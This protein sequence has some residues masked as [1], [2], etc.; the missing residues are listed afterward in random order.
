MNFADARATLRKMAKGRR[1]HTFEHH[2]LKI[3]IWPEEVD[4]KP[5]YEVYISGHGTG[6]G[7]SWKEAFD[8]L[9]EEMVGNEG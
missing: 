4:K 8:K 9:R 2:T 5:D 7:K 3:I 1:Y 6:I